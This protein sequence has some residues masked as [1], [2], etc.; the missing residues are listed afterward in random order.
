MTRSRA[1]ALAVFA[2]TA[3]ALLPDLGGQYV[4]SKDEARPAL[5]ARDMVERGHWL[6]PHIGSRIYANKPPLFS[7]LVALLSPGGV[8]EWSLRLPSVLAAAGTATATW[9]IGAHLGGMAMGVVAA[10]VLVSSAAFVEWAR[11]GRMEMLVVFWI[12]LGFW[13]GLHWLERGRRYH[14]VLL[15]L[16]L[17]FG[18]LT[19][20]PVALLPLAAVVIALGV[21][22]AWSPRRLADLALVVGIA[23]ALPL[24]WL[25]LAAGAHESFG[26]YARAVFTTVASDV[27]VR[28]P[29]HP[30]YAL[31]VL[32]VG[33]LPWT[34]VVPGA[35]LVLVRSWKRA[36]R[37]LLLPLLW[38]ALVIVVLAAV[39]S[40]RDAHFLPIY[41][42]L[43]LLVA[44]AW[45]SCSPR[46]RPWMAVPLGL[47][48][49]ALVGV[50][51]FLA[52]SPRAI[53]S[54]KRV[55]V[56]GRGPA[57]AMAALGA[58]AGLGALALARRRRAQAA[59][60]ALAAGALGV[61]MVVEVAIDTPRANRSYPTREVAARL[62]AVLPP[63]A[64]VAYFDRKFSTG[65]VFYLRQRPV[66]VLGMPAL[67]ALASR[68]GSHALLPIA[69][70]V[71]AH[72]AVCL[73]TRTLRE[74]RVFGEPYVLVDF[75][76]LPAEW[77]FWPP[78]M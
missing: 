17:G 51:A 36:W 26:T 59:A 49:L 1:V 56:L 5:V 55:T 44:W 47:A 61:L 27:A 35:L 4:W 37:T 16:A 66:E 29:H 43:A 10:A 64:E 8:T 14:A 41:P 45:S 68:P 73:P 74:E 75:G 77:C 72:G 32:G 13:S 60:V 52:L 22:G 40:P 20:G 58:A 3:L 9:A 57:V 30:L 53:E 54:A 76:G 69:E 31:E 62:A 12:A 78:G 65:L 15:A 18:C 38:A 34:V 63:E 25:G 33:F 24:T 23:A 21:P 19:K 42:A 50:G 67:R 46:E 48:V 2:V 39:L 6:I 11:T 70:M 28:R 7:W 71:F